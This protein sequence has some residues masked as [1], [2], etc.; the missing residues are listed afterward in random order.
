[1]RAALSL[2]LG[3]LRSGARVEASVVTAA[4]GPESESAR[5]ETR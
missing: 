2:T 4:P 1:M 3:R 5:T